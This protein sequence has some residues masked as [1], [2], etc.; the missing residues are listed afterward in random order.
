MAFAFA[1]GMERHKADLVEKKNT[2]R[3]PGGLLA[4]S[5]N[6]FNIAIESDVVPP[7]AIRRLVDHGASLQVRDNAC[8]GV[9]MPSRL[10]RRS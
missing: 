1:V 9:V 10:S 3:R 8:P 4:P 6:T 2:R 7:E 5:T